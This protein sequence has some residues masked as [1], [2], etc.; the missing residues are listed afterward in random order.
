M[1]TFVEIPIHDHHGVCHLLYAYSQSDA[2]NA[3]RLFP[4]ESMKALDPLDRS[5]HPRRHMLSHLDHLVL[6]PPNERG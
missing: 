4:P 3:V 1:T 5:K 2:R 6:N